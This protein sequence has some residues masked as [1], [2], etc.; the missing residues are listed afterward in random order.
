[1]QINADSEVENCAIN[2]LEKKTKLLAKTGLAY[3]RRRVRKQPNSPNWF[4]EVSARGMRRKLSLDT[5]N[6]ENAAARARD[7]YQIARA[8]GWDAVQAKYRPNAVEVKNNLSVGQ[9]I[10]LA[11]S[12]A[13]VEKVTWRGYV[14]AFRR[15]VSD[16]F[17]LDLGKKKFDPYGGGHQEWVQRVDAVKL[18]NLT[19]QKIQQW[20]RSFLSYAALDPISQRSAKTSVNT[21]LRQAHTCPR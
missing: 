12:V 17:D 9:F 15:I 13:N 21:Y 8:A 2:A 3:W 14:A 10:A 20:K 19:P 6:R 5:P 11:E 7:I 4:V 18:A 1:M 16:L